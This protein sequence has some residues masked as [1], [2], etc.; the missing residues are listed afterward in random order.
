MCS[1]V[2]DR[3]NRM[4][5]IEGWGSRR[6]RKERKGWVD[7]CLDRIYRMDRILV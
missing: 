1:V 7:E 2:L 5:G 3:I 4:D 6:E